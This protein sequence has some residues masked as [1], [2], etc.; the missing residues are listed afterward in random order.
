MDYQGFAALERVEVRHRGEWVAA[1]VLIPAKA[2]N[3]YETHVVL[4]K[5]ESTWVMPDEIRPSTHVADY[6]ERLQQLRMKLAS[7]AERL[8]DNCEVNTAAGID[9]AEDLL[10]D[11]FPELISGKTV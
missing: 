8:R 3:D 10:L 7:E 6:V 2:E 5:G 11:L 4:E 9:F 1:K